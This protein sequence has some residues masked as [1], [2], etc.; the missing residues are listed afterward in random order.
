[1]RFK[2]VKTPVSISKCSSYKHEEVQTALLRCVN[3][4]G[5]ISAFVEPGDNVM[6][7]PNMLQGKSPDE[8]I[9]THPAVVEAVVNMVKDA[10]AV[11]M[12]GD[13]PGGPA[14]GMKSF[15]D[16]TGFSEVSKR[17]GA[18]LVNFEKTGSNK[19]YRNNIEYRISKKVLESDFVINIP[20]IKTHGLTIFTC[21]IKNMYGVVPGLIKT[22]YHKKAPNPSK[23]A[24]Y[25]VDIYALSKPHLNIVDGIVGMDG[26]GPSSGDPKELGMILASTDGVAVDVL[27][28]DMLGKDPMK[29]PCNR[30]AVEQ[31]LGVGDLDKI[32]VIGEAPIV[33]D[34]K[35]PPNIS[36][37]LDMIP[38]KIARFLM[39]LYW[40]RP[41]IDKELCNNCE[42][43]VKSCPV[44]A[45]IENTPVPQF[46]Y[47]KC[48]NCLCC[49]EMCPEKAV[50]EEKSRL[51]RL[52]SS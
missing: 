23:F 42:T 40:S 13:S 27:S 1:M 38:P 24:E 28:C 9:T 36:S 15:W 43:C 5:G 12:I 33:D 35:W 3:A 17:T 31:K 29:V 8:A 34:F 37:S 26:T 41:A 6:I 19:K 2:M 48:I 44:D 51:S 39:K 25:V 21:A 52:I 22:E 49:M 7:K 30:I 18:E 11:P 45:L 32:E 14:R 50:F 4:I 47:G 16:I 10:G 20:K 46:E